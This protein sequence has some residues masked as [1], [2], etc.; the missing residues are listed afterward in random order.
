[1][2]CRSCG[3]EERASEGY[4]CASCTTFICVLCTLRGVTLCRECVAKGV[5]AEQKPPPASSD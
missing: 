1:M 5:A 2:I 3:L 4:P